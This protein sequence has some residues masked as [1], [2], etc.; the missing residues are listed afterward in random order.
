MIRAKI[1]FIE[2]AIVSNSAEN[3]ELLDA[4]KN[5]RNLL[6]QIDFNSEIVPLESAKSLCK[7]LESLKN[8]PLSSQEMLLA[9]KLVKFK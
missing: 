8:E 7:L 6:D 1:L 2:Q 3:T 5:V 4:I 9:K